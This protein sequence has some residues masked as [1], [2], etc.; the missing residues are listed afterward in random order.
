[1][2]NACHSEKQICAQHAAGGS[3]YD[4][5][6]Y[7]GLGAGLTCYYGAF[8]PSEAVLYKQGDNSHAHASLHA[9]TYFF[10]VVVEA[11]PVADR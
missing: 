10:L 8:R 4:P 11:A 7:S 2:R 9:H 5:S 1:M 3:A 6:I